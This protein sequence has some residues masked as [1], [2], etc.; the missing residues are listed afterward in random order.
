VPKLAFYDFPA[1]HWQHV[2]ITNPNESV[3]ATVRHWT[4][5]IPTKMGTRSNGSWATVPI[6]RGQRFQSKLGSVLPGADGRGRLRVGCTFS[7]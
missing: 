7:T 5:R 6:D 2:R 1:E 3:F 4:V